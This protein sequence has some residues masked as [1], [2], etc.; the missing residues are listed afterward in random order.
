M[1]WCPAE[2]CVRQIKGEKT[3]AS[4]LIER[5]CHYK[6]EGEC[7]YEHEFK[8]RMNYANKLTGDKEHKPTGEPVQGSN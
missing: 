7:P 5:T 6:E 8:R 3:E 4:F 2:N 1:N